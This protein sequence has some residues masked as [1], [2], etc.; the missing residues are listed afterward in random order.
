MQI[1]LLTLLFVMDRE[2]M[3]LKL[4]HLRN[5]QYCIHDINYSLP[6]HIFAFLFSLI[7]YFYSYFFP[8]FIV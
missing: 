5:Y 8:L 4:R 6:S 3:V 1:V 2:L 7:L